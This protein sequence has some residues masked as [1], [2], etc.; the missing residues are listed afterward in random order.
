MRTNLTA[1]LLF[2]IVAFFPSTCYGENVASLVFEEP[3]AGH[4]EAEN[5]SEELVPPEGKVGVLCTF[6]DSSFAV[7]SVDDFAVFSPEGERIPLV[8]DESNVLEEFGD[9]YSIRFVFFINRSAIDSALPHTVKWG[10]G[11]EGENTLLGEFSL[12]QDVM[13]MYRECTW[14]AGV[15]EGAD[16]SVATIEVIVDESADYY[17]LWYLLPMALLFIVLTIRKLKASDLTTRAAS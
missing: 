1:L 10:E 8:I 15:A 5:T 6:N 3:R 17:S 4:F 14:V 13:K 11:I 12:A 16:S 2:L 7:A 9:I